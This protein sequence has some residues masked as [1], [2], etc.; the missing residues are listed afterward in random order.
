MQRFSLELYTPLPAPLHFS[1]FFKNHL[2][3]TESR[4]GR[5]D[6][7]RIAREEDDAVGVT[8]HP[9]GLVVVDVVDGVRH[10]GV[11]RLG[12]V[13]V[14]RVAVALINKQNKKKTEQRKAEK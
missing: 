13:G 10:A 4:H 3:G 2:A 12:Y 11:L 8:A 1:P 14:V 6:A 5:K 7:E 9:R